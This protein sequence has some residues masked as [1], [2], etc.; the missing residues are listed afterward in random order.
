MQVMAED[1][2]RDRARNE[3][4]EA[5]LNAHEDGFALLGPDHRLLRANLP[6]CRNYGLAPEDVEGRY[7]WEVE[8]E[9]H[10]RALTKAALDTALSGQ[11]TGYEHWYNY[12]ARGRVYREVRY[13]PVRAG[14]SA[15]SV[16]CVIRDA[17]A[18][19]LAEEYLRES[20]DRL[21]A[22][23]RQS[24]ECI[25]ITDEENG[26][27]MA[28]NDRFTSFVGYSVDESLGR[29]TT[30]L[31][32]WPDED[33]R[34]SL[35]ADLPQDGGVRSL[36][37]RCRHKDGRAVFGWATI[38]RVTVSGRA[39]LLW[40][41]Q[42][43]T[44]AKRVRAELVRKDILLQSILDHTDL[45]FH[46]KDAEGRYVD[47]NKRFVELFGVSREE[48][49]GRTN[50]DVH[51]QAVAEL[52]DAHDRLVLLTGRQRTYEETIV[53]GRKPYRFVTTVFPIFDETGKTMAVGTVAA[54]VT[55]LRRAEAAAMERGLFFDAW[56]QHNPAPMLL[57]GKVT[58]KLLE[59]NAA[60]RQLFGMV[61]GKQVRRTLDSLL[62]PV[63]KADS[64]ALSAVAQGS[65]ARSVVRVLKRKGSMTFEIRSAE[66]SWK[67][68]EVLSLSL[69]DLTDR[70]R[71][72]E[73]LSRHQEELEVKAAQLSEA[74]AA[75]RALVRSVE[76]EKEEL[77]RRVLGN[78]RGVVQPILSTLVHR[79]KT[80]GEQ[81]TLSALETV[82]ERM[83][84]LT[85]PFFHHLLSTR[86]DL[87]VSEIRVAEL[88]KTGKKN[89]EIA[90]TLSVS[91]KTVEYYRDQ[92]RRKLGLTGEKA[93]LKAHLLAVEARAGGMVALR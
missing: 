60:A 24:P 70:V 56:F 37:I 79:A 17:T 75:L 83:N 38:S 11:E 57:V 22:I 77:E 25:V 34:E 16:L 68:A 61:E 55:G 1:L 5:V 64:R 27:I 29:S 51:P 4:F 74:N 21:D 86:P 78:V 48:M 84:Q 44:D 28:A 26:L 66:M 88:V 58:G 91:V 87:T 39:C 7:V 80:Q 90:Q 69:F 62:D 54:D 93:N 6:F 31:D 76:V 43:I 49:I 72:E 71:M 9:Q 46:L 41:V 32:L 67:G 30:E 81:A 82:E 85:S 20:L 18:R 2:K 14:G 65:E 13:R 40:L 59:A 47:V 12:P 35:L 15:G 19:M 53:A 23:F 89:K 50:Q 10:Y 42:D 52:V 92:L 45:V 33:G 3:F 73:A 36:E 63:S 8:G